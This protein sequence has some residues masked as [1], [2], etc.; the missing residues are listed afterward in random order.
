MAKIATSAGF[1]LLEL[2]LALTLTALLTLGAFSSLDMSLK[3]IGRGQ[4]LAEKLQEVR[5]GQ[6]ILERSLSSAVRGSVREKVYFAGDSRQMRFFTLIPLEAY[7]LGGVY[8]WRVLLGQDESGR[9]VLA[10]EQ[11]RNLNWQRDPQGVE[12]RKIILR[13]VTSLSVDYGLGSQAFAT[14]DGFKK[15]R[16][17][18]WVRL[19]VALK[20]QEPQVWLIPMHVSENADWKK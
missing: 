13:N 16:L 19:R 11:T 6:N 7:N 12:V 9:D 5:V 1:T 8:H 4:A 18:D 10:V 14:W 20:G 3:T 17:P 15:G 2:L